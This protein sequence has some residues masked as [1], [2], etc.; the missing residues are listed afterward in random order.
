MGAVHGELAAFP[1]PWKP[2]RKYIL[3]RTPRPFPLAD[4]TLA[5]PPGEAGRL[6]DVQP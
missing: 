6:F 2:G 1:G 5:L 4:G 3:C